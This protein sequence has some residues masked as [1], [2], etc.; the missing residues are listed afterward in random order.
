MKSCQKILPGEESYFFIS[1]VIN[2]VIFWH[3][4]GFYY[5]KLTYDTNS[6]LIQNLPDRNG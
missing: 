2:E 5:E 1:L 3:G 4:L 6:Q